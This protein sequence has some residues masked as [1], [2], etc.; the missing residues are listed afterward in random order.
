MA[1]L[2]AYMSTLLDRKRQEPAADVVSDLAAAQEQ[3]PGGL[4]DEHVT[5]LAAALLWAGH[6]TTVAAI[7]RG[8]LLLLQNLDQRLALEGNPALIPSTVEEI[9]RNTFPM[10][11][12]PDGV[13]R[14]TRVDVAVGGVTIPAGDLVL[15][16]M[17]SA[18]LDRRVFDDPGVFDVTRQGNP[19]LTFGHGPHYCL[20]APLA[21]I[22]LQ[23]V[24][25]T[26]FKRFPG[27]QLAVPAEELRI[28]SDRLI[29]GLVELPVTW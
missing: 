18:N 27:L 11:E 2:R 4:T 23:V 29:R 13:P 28:R 16:A 1:E 17:Q 10:E 5:T 24:F 14:W 7:D 19:D 25:G 8:V 12:Q 6:E 15:L 3:L 20:G 26:L 22:E 9:L 21:R